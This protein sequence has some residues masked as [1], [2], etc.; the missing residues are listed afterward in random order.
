MGDGDAVEV[1]SLRWKDEMKTTVR[2]LVVDDNPLIRSA[3]RAMLSGLEDDSIQWVGQAETGEAGERLAIK[4]MPDVVLMDVSMPGRGGV[5]AT[6]RIREQVSGAKVIAFSAHEDRHR[7]TEMLD[8]G[9]SG[10]V[11]KC[12]RDGGGAIIQ[13]IRTVSSG[14]IYLSDELKTPLLGTG[15]LSSEMS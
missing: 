1:G 6:R 7:V 12:G 13:A 2:V 4:L 9:A 5:E 11:L 15:A 8:A 10:Y 3:V 14:G